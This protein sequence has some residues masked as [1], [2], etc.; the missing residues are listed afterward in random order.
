[1]VIIDGLFAK[2]YSN[3]KVERAKEKGKGI[4]YE[5]FRDDIAF[6]GEPNAKLELE[7]GHIMNGN[8]YE[9]LAVKRVKATGKDEK[10]TNP[11][12]L[13]LAT[14]DLRDIKTKV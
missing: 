14:I 8:S 10:E 2:C 5:A 7:G 9:F 6:E 4:T 3:K 11:R 13:F 1:M 12:Y